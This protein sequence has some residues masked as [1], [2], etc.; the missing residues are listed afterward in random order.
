MGAADARLGRVRWLSDARGS[1]ALEGALDIFVGVAEGDGAS[2]GAGGGVFGFAEFG[3]EPVD[4]GGIEGLV[5][6]DG[7]VAG[8]AGGDAAAAGFGVFAL[9]IAVGNGEDLFEHALEFD[10]FEADGSGFNGEGAGAEGF[11]FET[12]A[13]EFFGNFGEGDHLG[14]EHVD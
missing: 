9:L 8:D 7:G 10:A 14:G 6:L 12:V 11:G 3:E 4:L 13:V 2:V 5:D 1:D